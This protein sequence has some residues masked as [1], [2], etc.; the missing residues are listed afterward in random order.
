MAA[1]VKELADLCDA[2]EV[3]FTTS[4]GMPDERDYAI[5]EMKDAWDRVDS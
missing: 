3:M 2:D 1:G 4:I 5:R